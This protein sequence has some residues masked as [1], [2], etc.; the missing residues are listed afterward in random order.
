VSAAS[1]YLEEGAGRIA[2]GWQQTNCQLKL[3]KAGL[4]ALGLQGEA[5]SKRPDVSWPLP[6]K[7]EAAEQVAPANPMRMN[8]AADAVVHDCEQQPRET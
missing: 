4:S 6:I 8:V 3:T 7:E 5:P 1:T 2:S